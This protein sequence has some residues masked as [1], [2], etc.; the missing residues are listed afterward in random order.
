MPVDFRFARVDEY[1]QAAHFLHDYWSVDHIYFKDKP[2]FDWTFHRATHWDPETY[3][4]AIAEDGGEWVGILGGIPFTFNHFG[5]KQRGVWIVNYVIRPDHRKGPTALQ[6]LSMFRR[7]PFEATIAFGINPA[8]SAIYRVLRGDVIDTIPRHFLVLPGAAGRMERLLEITN[9]DWSADRRSDLAR[10]FEAPDF[11]S[12]DVV[13]GNVIPASWDQCEWPRIASRT[14]GA[15]RD[16]AYLKW[17]Y[18]DHPR[19]EHRII[20]MGDES[21]KGLL[22]WRLETIR[23][24]TEHGREDVDR[25]GRLLEFL[26]SSP[27]NGVALLGA[28]A[29]ELRANDALGADYYG[30]HG[31]SAQLL[32]SFGFR[33]TSGHRD[34]SL[35]PS[36]FQPLDGK[37]GNIMSA[38][39]VKPGI[40]KCT[41]S[42][43]N[44]WYWTK[45]DSDQDRP[46]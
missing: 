45:S 12:S 38:M 15:E 16:S 19:F 2:L 20:T 25:F 32:N 23:R 43:E 46:N 40:P 37:G 36:R 42:P 39:F 31:A 24:A 27:E 18:L 30:Y 35:L 13:R 34:G 41:P 3:S 44:N 11:A 14:I 28:F 21:Q 6:L 4:F 26:P 5:E 7:E 8:T 17:R 9:Q 33:S 1:D 29:E 10:G 22:I